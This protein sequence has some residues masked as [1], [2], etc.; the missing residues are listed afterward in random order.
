MP[1]NIT[2]FF[3]DGTAHQY[4]N[5]PDVLT[6]DDIEKRTKR[7]YPDKKIIR[8]DGGKK[9][10][11]K[12]TQDNTLDK[13]K[14][15]VLKSFKFTYETHNILSVRREGSYLIVLKQITDYKQQPDLYTIHIFNE[16]NGTG[17]LP[18]QG[19]GRVDFDADMDGQQ[20]YVNAKSQ[21][22]KPFKPGRE[23]PLGRGSRGM[24]FQAAQSL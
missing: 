18:A 23:Y 16:E 14:I 6:P 24:T 7:D 5:A 20:A 22:N 17:V 2:V 13:S 19:W 9:N 15:R 4:N 1:R 8:I 3:S 10:Q 21:F 12:S 11:E